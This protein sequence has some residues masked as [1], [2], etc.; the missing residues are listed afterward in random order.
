M[1][2]F[3]ILWRRELAASF[4]SP[5]AYI[6]MMFFLA[7]MGYIFW[8][9]ASVLADGP[10][11]VTA[12]HLFFASPFF[13]MVLLVIVPVLTMRVLAEEK[14]SGTIETLLCAPVSD[15]AVVLAKYA[16]VLAFYVAMWLPT[17][18]YL[19]VLHRFSAVMAPVDPACVATGYLGVLLVGAFYLSIGVFASALTSNQII[20]AITA[21]ALTGVFF[22]T[23]FLEV[24]GHGETLRRIGAHVSSY[25]HLYDFSRGVI[26]SRPIAFYLLGTAFFLFAAVR[27]VGS[28]RWK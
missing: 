25:T 7:V 23:G 20:A 4:L 17:L 21:F 10:G 3:L 27:V 24:A 15:T 5:I 6:V 2:G 13:W 28:R 8:F 11:G 18:S 26:D 1:K 9:L 22:F 12:L 19:H 14:R 16:G